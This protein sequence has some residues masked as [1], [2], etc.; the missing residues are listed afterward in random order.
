MPGALATKAALA[1]HPRWEEEN[2]RN[3]TMPAAIGNR[4]IGGSRSPVRT[5]PAPKHSFDA[6]GVREQ[7]RSSG[8][9]FLR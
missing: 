2:Q 8:N 3:P 6:T 1:S 5:A 4:G 7:I 9:A